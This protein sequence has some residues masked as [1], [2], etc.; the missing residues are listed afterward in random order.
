VDQEALG[1]ALMHEFSHQYLHRLFD[2][3]GPLWFVEGMAEYFRSYSIEMG[4]VRPGAECSDHRERL[5]RAQKD[6]TFIPLSE[7][8]TLHRDAFYSSDSLLPYAEAWWLIRHI[9]HPAS[10][11][12]RDALVALLQGASLQEIM[13]LEEME[14]EWLKSLE[15]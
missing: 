10:D 4:V 1:R 2:L 6:G 8:V 12:H 13:P 9:L 15:E 14:K 3:V 11:V 7:L 5:R